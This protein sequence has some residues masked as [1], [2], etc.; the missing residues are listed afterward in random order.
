M[1][2]SIQQLPNNSGTT[3]V[4]EVYTSTGFNAGDP[5]YFQNGDY[6]N[7]TNLTAPST[8][9]F[10]FVN[11][12]AIA[13]N[14]PTGVGGI[15]APSFTYADMQTG[16]GGG[17]ARRFASVLTNG[18]IVQAW[19]MYNN[20]PTNNNRVHFRV[21]TPT[22]T[23]V[24]AP[25][26]VSSTFVS[27]TYACVSVVALVG[28]GFAVGW[29]N[30]SGGTSN[31]ANYAIYD[32]AGTVVTAATQ[33]TTLSFGSGGTYCPLEMTALAN[34]GFAIAIKNTGA[35]LY[36]RAYSSTGVA[37]YTAINTGITAAA[38]ENSFALT[39]RSDSSVFVCDRY[40]TTTYYYNL[41][42][43]GGTSITGGL[44][45]STPAGIGSGGYVGS[46]DAS[47]L[48]DGTTIV[49]GYYSANGTYGYP[50]I[51]LLPTGN[52][53]GAE[54]IA[55]PVANSFY[56]TNYSGVYLSVQTLSSSNFILYFS[57]GYGNMQ[58]AFYNSSG[59]CIS[60]SNGTGAIPL[61]V[62]GGFCSANNR[63]TLLESSGFVYA[64][65][66]AAKNNQKPTQ[67]VFC[68][69]NTTSYLVTP[70]LS[71]TGS[72][73][74]VTG[75]PTGASI[76]STVN[77][78]SLSYYS[79]SSSSTVATNTP[80]TQI[81]P[82]A[83]SSSAV[84]S[85]ANCVLPNGNFVIVWKVSTGYAVF[86]NVYSIT[87]GLLSSISVGTGAAGNFGLRV[88]ALSDGGF[89]VA[90]HT[91][92]TVLTLARYSSGYSFSSSTTITINTYSVVYN[93]DIAGLPDGKCVVF[94]SLDGTNARVQVFSSSFTSL[95]TIS[96]SGTPQGLAVANNSWGGFAIAYYR[97]SSTGNAISYVP[98]GTDAWTAV[99]ASG[100]S[101]CDAYP[102]NP[103][104][105]ATESGLYIYTQ[106]TSS[107]PSYGMWSDPGSALVSYTSSLSSWPL[108]SAN[109]PTSNPCMGIGLTGDGNVVIATSYNSTSLGIACVP[110]QMTFSTGQGVEYSI[111]GS[112][113][114][115]MFSKNGYTTSVVYGTSAQPRV[116]SSAGSN[117][118]IS[119]IGANQYPSFMIING[120]SNSN[121]YSI[122]A[123]V[124][125]SALTPIAPVATSG[126]ISG[127]FA[128]VAITSATAGSTG[129]L[130][131]NGQA[132]LGASYTST[133][134]GAFDSTGGAVSGLKGTFN[135]RS[136]NLQG[137]S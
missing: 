115:P 123:G 8:V 130:A 20:A 6:K 105:C 34:G 131:T 112:N 133:A 65:W 54:I 11:N 7:P 111:T 38:N 119:F 62:N 23:V 92:S 78:N 63:V 98:T 16:V 91:S 120:A 66:T 67:Q 76:P 114:I 45:F 71:V 9:N 10:N 14:S 127:A 51:R 57:D 33:D 87:G 109:S 22:G 26:L 43:S 90:Y 49:I 104:L 69:I 124:T 74:T 113:S 101:N 40:D 134:T 129:Q 79:T 18:N 55:I 136:V 107:F 30:S 53:M 21:I 77:P 60:G 27:A 89:I 137:N 75:Q 5:V 46:P 83:V 13:P 1:S 3:N 4:T 44:S 93:Y 99:A 72:P 29:G 17:T 42:N 70:F 64:Y 59:T 39:S 15:I 12:A 94:Y 36:L 116:A 85:V 80:A 103:Q 31:V 61:Q 56:S 35:T 108:G 24:V 110:A 86:A 97:Q 2:R 118:I 52:T 50:A 68:K 47:V 25:T 82:V 88:C 128:G 125:P 102:Q 41:Y 73:Y 84:D 32:N 95:Q 28:G 135:G 100:L 58:Y 117:A 19:S 37:A 48:P 106:S 81:G 121:I 132:L 122:T 96:V 126:V